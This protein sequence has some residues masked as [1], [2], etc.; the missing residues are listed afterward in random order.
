MKLQGRS[1]NWVTN[2]SLYKKISYS[3]FVIVGLLTI[4]SLSMYMNT[5]RVF[6]NLLYKESANSLSFIAKNITA[7]LQ[8]IDQ[9]TELLVVTQNLQSNLSKN[10]TSLSSFEQNHLKKTVEDQLYTYFYSNKFIDSITMITE[11]YTI[12]TGNSVLQENQEYQNEMILAARA[13]RGK[14]VWYPS[15]EKDGTILLVRSVLKVENLDL[16][17]LGTLIVRINF[18]DILTLAMNSYDYL[19]SDCPLLIYTDTT[20]FHDASSNTSDLS[21]LSASLNQPYSILHIDGAET[22]CVTRKMKD[23]DWIYTLLVPYNTI[24]QTI[25]TSLLTFVVLLALLAF[26]IQFISDLMIRKVT[27]HFHNL[28]RKME[29]LRHGDTDA[30]DVHYDYSTRQDEIGL[31]HQNFD[32]MLHDFKHLTL[33]NYAKQLLIKDTQLKALRQQINPHFLYNTLDSINWRA[34]AL[35]DNDTSV[36]VESLGKLLRYALN[37]QGDLVTLQEEL[38]IAEH[39]INIQKIRFGDRLNY[40]CETCEPFH[41]S[42]VPK[43]SIQPLLENAIKY[44]VEHLVV[45]GCIHLQIKGSLEELTILVTNDGSE[46]P[47]NI[48]ELLQTGAYHTAGF[49]IGLQNIDSRIKLLFGEKYGLTFH[50]KNEVTTVTM[51]LP[52]QTE[53]ERKNELVT[54]K[55][56]FPC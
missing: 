53:P 15:Y 16:S 27:L 29:V 10:Y 31:L 17:E 50:S 34:K 5:T 55:E 12:C 3:S 35:R 1:R 39:Y 54:E 28:S 51:N 30:V 13:N 4:F 56:I 11:N 38:L 23:P 52:N 20:I 26:I 36:M 47:T 33:D 45:P 21:A 7:Q 42:L 8:V 40:I 44:G 2:L 18:D 22:F 49:G 25:N 46:I 9:S 41:S 19:S 24:F 32:S 43:M 48:L 6:S 14:E 37:E